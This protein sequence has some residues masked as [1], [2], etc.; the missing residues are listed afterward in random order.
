M[1][2]AYILVQTEVGKAAEVAS[3]HRADHRRHPGRRRHRTLRRHRP[4]R[5]GQRGRPRP[6]GR[7]PDPGSRG[8]HQ[9]ADLPDRAH[10]GRGH[11]P[12][13]SGAALAA[14]DAGRIARADGATSGG[15]AVCGQQ[16][17]GVRAETDLS[18]CAQVGDGVDV[19]AQAASARVS[20]RVPISTAPVARCRSR[21]SRPEPRPE[22]APPAPPRTASSRCRRHRERRRPRVGPPSAERRCSSPGLDRGQV[23]RQPGPASVR[24]LSPVNRPRHGPSA[25]FSPAPGRS[26]QHQGAEARPRCSLTSGS[27]VTTRTTPTSAA[28][29]RRRD[30]VGRHGQRELSAPLAS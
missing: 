20:R 11:W 25:S 9:D 19:P 12:P 2:Q 17:P 14:A 21:E 22:L 4:G 7:R 24:P 8:H 23:A 1:V 16:S 13:G 15:Q 27:S 28:L 10:L 18:G 30:G 5:V 26:A 3:R 6:A 29:N